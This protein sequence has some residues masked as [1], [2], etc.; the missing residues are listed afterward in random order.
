MSKNLNEILQ[1]ST[2]F[3]AFISILFYWIGY[4]LQKKLKKPFLNPLLVALVL[5]IALLSFLQVDY[6]TY[7]L[8]AKYIT[9]F[10]TPATVCLAVP[11]YKQLTLLKENFAAI[12]I[13]ILAGCISHLIVVAGLSFLFHWNRDFLFS[14]LPKSVTTPIALG[15]CNETGGMEE[16]TIIGV[17]IAGLSGSI[18]G[19]ALLKLFHIKN[20]IAQ[21]LALGTASHAIGTSKAVELGDIQAAVSSVAIVITGIMT[22]V[23]IPVYIHLFLQ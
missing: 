2:Y 21:G 5:I 14:F 12:L 11:L 16:L 20:P 7:Q 22:V 17:T 3:G 13:A 23:L 4:Y 19:P 8:S 15:I 18:L 9:Y 6:E 1:Q 10:L